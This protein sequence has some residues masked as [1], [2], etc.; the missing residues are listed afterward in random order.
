MGFLLTGPE[1]ATD[2]DFD[3]DISFLALAHSQ[4]VFLIQGVKYI[5]ACSSDKSNTSIGMFGTEAL[6]FV[7]L[8]Q[9]FS[10]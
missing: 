7:G 6:I 3:V 10:F 8:F 2:T 9:I 5:I 4:I 1:E